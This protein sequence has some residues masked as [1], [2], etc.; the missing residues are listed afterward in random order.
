MCWRTCAEECDNMRRRVTAM[1]R[2]ARLRETNKNKTR[3]TNETTRCENTME[4]DSKRAE[5]PSGSLNKNRSQVG[6]TILNSGTQVGAA[7]CWAPDE[8]VDEGDLV[9]WYNPLLILHGGQGL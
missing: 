4:D 6:E 8:N 2:E 5:M 7:Y 1:E 9:S 3:A